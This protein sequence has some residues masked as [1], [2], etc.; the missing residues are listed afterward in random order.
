MLK[1]EKG[2]LT[3]TIQPSSF[4]HNHARKRQT[5]DYTVV[6]TKMQRCSEKFIVAG[7]RGKK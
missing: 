5:L 4:V 3:G 7:L 6:A 2:E 1:T